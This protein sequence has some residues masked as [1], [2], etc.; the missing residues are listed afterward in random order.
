MCHWLLFQGRY[1]HV[2]IFIFSELLLELIELVIHYLESRNA[3][4][5]MFL[6][7]FESK[8]A[9]LFYCLLTESNFSESLRHELIRLI[10]VLLR[11]HKVSAR[12]KHRMHLKEA[13]YLGLLHLRTK[14]ISA[15]MTSNEAIGLLDIMFMFDDATT[16]Q[17]SL[18]QTLSFGLGFNPKLGT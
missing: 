8:R 17:V 16:Y 6:I 5:Q 11:T 18:E 12:H 1:I 13:R 7:M 4:D 15:A 14:N 2:R 9:D 3:K 10:L